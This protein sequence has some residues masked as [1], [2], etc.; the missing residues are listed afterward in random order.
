VQI[1]DEIRRCVVFLY[2]SG[3][4]GRRPV[5]TGFFVSMYLSDVS[6]LARGTYLV[7]AKHIVEGVHRA[8]EEL[9]SGDIELI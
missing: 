9:K 8:G 7:T 1:P 6:R 4:A 3:T 5:G 2:A